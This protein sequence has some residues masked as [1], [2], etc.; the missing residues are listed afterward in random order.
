MDFADLFSGGRVAAPSPENDPEA[1]T[2]PSLWSAVG[3]GVLGDLSDSD[4]DALLTSTQP[5]AN[6]DIL[7][8]QSLGELFNPLRTLAI[9]GGAQTAGYT[10]SAAA[11]HWPDRPMSPIAPRGMDRQVQFAPGNESGCVDSYVR[12][13]D[14]VGNRRY[15]SGY[16]CSDCLHYCKTQ[17]RWPSSLCPHG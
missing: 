16:T 7:A 6:T 17:G 3:H 9:G 5:S 13:Q 8:P 14:A 15:D 10:S 1:Q 11:A 2:T 4:I 12:C